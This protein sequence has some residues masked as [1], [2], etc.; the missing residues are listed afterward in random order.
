M[1]PQAEMIREMTIDSLIEDVKTALREFWER[2]DDAA[3]FDED[4][5]PEEG[6]IKAS[7][8]IIGRAKYDLEKRTLKQLHPLMGDSR[9][10]SAMRTSMID[11]Y[12]DDAVD[13]VE[14]CF[15]DVA[16]RLQ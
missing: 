10:A 14:D 13:A 5:V 8:A 12:L 16:Y 6:R 15:D 1:T 11:H 7:T 3:E 9:H 4:T 2:H